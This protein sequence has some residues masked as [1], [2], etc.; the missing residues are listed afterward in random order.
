MQAHSAFILTNHPFS[1]YYKN[2]FKGTKAYQGAVPVRVHL[3][4]SE[5]ISGS[6]AE[7]CLQVVKAALAGLQRRAP[8]RGGQVARFGSGLLSFGCVYS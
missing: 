5:G 1:N 3:H 7:G 2:L 6:A 8:N 4:K